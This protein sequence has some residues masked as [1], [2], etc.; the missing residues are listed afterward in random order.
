MISQIFYEN[1][2]VIV[3]VIIYLSHLKILVETLNKVMQL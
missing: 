3:C 1:L 2:E